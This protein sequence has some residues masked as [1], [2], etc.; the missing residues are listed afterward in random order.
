MVIG[1]TGGVGCGKSAVLK[2]LNEK[3]GCYIIESDKAGHLVMQNGMKA[4]GQIVRE[5]GEDI[6]DSERKIDR[7]KL[8]GIV[9]A[10]RE[11]LEK[12]NRI[13]H[14]A[15]RKCIVNEIARM[16][17]EDAGTVIVVESALLLEEHYKQFCDEVWYVYAPE[18]VRRKR[19]ADGR[20][21]TAQKTEQIMKNQKS[22]E[23]FLNGCD[24]KIDNSGDI[25]NTFRQ[26]KEI[27]DTYFLEDRY[28]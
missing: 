16:K 28:G 13:V 4:Y 9:F 19:L 17:E 27:F 25:D 23:E 24:R 22:E 12:L 14:P 8:A 1:V 15:V 18:E 21:Y 5:F 11:K 2:I 3:F 20:G 26:I 7:A 10:D 6:L